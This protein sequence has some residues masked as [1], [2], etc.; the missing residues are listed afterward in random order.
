M[1]SEAIRVEQDEVHWRLGE[2]V[3]NVLRAKWVLLTYML[4]GLGLGVLLALVLPPYYEGEAVFLPPKNTDLIPGMGASM[5]GGGAAASLLLGGGDSAAD[6]YL[7]MLASRTVADDVIDRVG[8]ISIYKVSGHD[9]ARAK[10]K[11]ASTFSLRKNLLIYVQIK[12]DTPALAEKITNAYLDALYRLNGKMV[13][14]ASAHRAVFFDQ[15]LDQQK[16][17]L[18]QA[19]VAL[20]TVQEQTGFLLPVGEAQAGVAATAQLQAQVGAAEATLNGLLIGGTEQNPGVVQAR[21]L[22]NQ[23]RGQLARQQAG[24]EAG[25]P[26]AGL[27]SNRRLPQLT[28]DYIQKERE[29]RLREAVYG[30]LVQQYERARLSSA[31]P[32]QQF[33][34]VDLA[35]VPERKAG[36]PRTLIALGGLL[37]GTLGGLA[38]LFFRDR[39]ARSTALLSERTPAVQR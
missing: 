10:L 12:A 34:I 24:S 11:Q 15:Q 21:S 30:A 9:K 39:R 8:L 35:I 36:P 6:I 25:H 29:V 20:K 3:R 31:D 28:F 5:G 19:E 38:L 1:I 14:S 7:G 32:G 17:A 2:P 22:V 4:I 18:V 27:A 33:Q 23:L 16:A 37:L 13:A 26:S